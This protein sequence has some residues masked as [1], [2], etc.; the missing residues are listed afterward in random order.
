MPAAA[1]RW[2]CTAEQR[3]PD[4]RTGAVSQ[5]RKT[6]FSGL[7]RVEKEKV[8]V[9]TAGRNVRGRGRYDSSQ[10]SRGRESIYAA[11]VL[12]ELRHGMGLKS[13]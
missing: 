3:S 7:K 12:P 2:C 6:K 10:S 13:F 4:G 8:L 11:S 5:R 9:P 1:T